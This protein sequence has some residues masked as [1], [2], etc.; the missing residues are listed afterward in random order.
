[1]FLGLTLILL[2]IYLS[3]YLAYISFKASTNTVYRILKKLNFPSP[4]VPC[5]I[6]GKNNT[7]K[8]LPNSLEQFL[9]VPFYDT[10]ERQWR[11]SINLTIGAQLNIWN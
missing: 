6:V 3:T 8:D 4:F 9:F 5:L 11:Y 7:E 1:M 2:S 10:Q